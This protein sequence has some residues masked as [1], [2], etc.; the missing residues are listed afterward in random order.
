VYNITIEDIKK[1]LKEVREN[2]LQSRDSV[3][4]E[5]IRELARIAAGLKGK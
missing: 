1:R 5:H 3:K 4:M 2:I